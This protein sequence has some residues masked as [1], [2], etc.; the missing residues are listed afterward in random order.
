LRASAGALPTRPRNG[1]PERA[2]VAVHGELVVLTVGAREIEHVQRRARHGRVRVARELRGGDGPD[3]VLADPLDRPDARRRLPRGE[4]GVQI[5]RQLVGLLVA[6]R[7]GGIGPER[8]RLIVELDGRDVE[9][10][11]DR[12]RP[13]VV[14]IAVQRRGEPIVELRREHREVHPVGDVGQLRRQRERVRRAGE[15][16]EHGHDLAGRLLDLRRDRGADRLHVL[17]AAARQRE[18]DREPLGFTVVVGD[19]RGELLQLRGL[20]RPSR[21]SSAFRSTIASSR[22]GNSVAP[23]LACPRHL[24]T[25]PVSRFT[26]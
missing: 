9:P 15:R 4:R 26:R 14:L 16:H 20:H 11:E 12:G 19:R 10:A 8:D 6:R 22:L 23:G 24:Q 5:L 7:V 21:R 25:T 17:R 18:V 2:L 1:V 13:D 3:G